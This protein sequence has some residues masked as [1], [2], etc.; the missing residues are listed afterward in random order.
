MSLIDEDEME[1][2]YCG[3]IGMRIAT[4]RVLQKKT[5]KG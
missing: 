4:S 1:C 5:K 3:H 2:E